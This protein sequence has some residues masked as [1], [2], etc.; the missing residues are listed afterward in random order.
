VGG[1]GGSG[2]ANALC[3]RR[4]TDAVIIGAIGEPIAIVVGQV[5]GVILA[6]LLVSH[7]TGVIAAIDAGGLALFSEPELYDAISAELDVTKGRAAITVIEVTIVTLLKAVEDTIPAEAT[8]WI[9]GTVRVLAIS[10]AIEVIVE[11]VGTEGLKAKVAVGVTEALIILAVSEAIEVIIEAVGADF[12]AE[13]HRVSE[14]VKVVTVDLEVEVVV[15]A[16]I[17]EGLK[18]WVDRLA[19]AITG[20]AIGWVTLLWEDYDAIAANRERTGGVSDTADIGAVNEAIE[21][22][23]LAIITDLL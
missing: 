18:P 11:E 15:L 1:A 8:G 9:K 10:E 22:V 17:T 13:A 14:A 16:I 6:D 20:Q 23:V 21:V 4:V 12:N 5:V 19:V 3:A 2:L 7:L